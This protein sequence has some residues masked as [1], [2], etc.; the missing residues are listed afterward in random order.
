MH[1]ASAKP[2]DLEA[3]ISI[4]YDA[5]AELGDFRPLVASQLPPTY[6]KLL[7]HNHH[8]T[9]TVEAHH[10][11]LVDVEVLRRHETPTHYAREIVL[12]RQSDAAVVQYGIMRV[13]LD[14][15][16]P[17]VRAEIVAAQTPLGRILINHDV[18]RQIRLSALWGVE[19]GPTLQRCFSCDASRSTFGRTARILCDRE[20]AIE[21][22]EIV[23]PE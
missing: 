23:A 6:H 2:V 9:V 1:N 5:P 11:S 13:R 17:D 19:P 12:R 4:F 3:L 10:G 14:V 18:F 22:L 15:F 20:P 7:A 8:M 16:H 21:L